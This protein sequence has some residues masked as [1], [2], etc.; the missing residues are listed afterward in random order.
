MRLP[1][2]LCVVA[3]IGP[4]VAATL[5]YGSPPGGDSRSLTS[6]EA[7]RVFGGVNNK[8][9]EGY[10]PCFYNLESDWCLGEDETGCPNTLEGFEFPGANNKLCTRMSAGDNC[11]HD[12]ELDICFLTYECHI[13]SESMMCVKNASPLTFVGITKAVY[14]TACQP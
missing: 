3:L 6:A 9:P 12:P 10:E 8:C 7:A 14:S 13:D 2:W 4:L 1:R 11:T 5:S